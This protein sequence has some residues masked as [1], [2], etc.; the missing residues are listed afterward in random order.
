[1]RQEFV[2]RRI[3]EA[4]RRREAPQFLEDADE[5]CLLVRE[6]FGQRRLPIFGLVR[7]NHL[8]H[9][10]NAITLK[11]HVLGAGQTNPGG[12]E[13]H[14]IGGLLWSVSISPHLQTSY[15]RAP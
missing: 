4:N 7:Q 15:L 13:S 6:Q 10:V 8:S 12:A 2:Q 1:M 11:E 9:G 14:R 5:V 3:E